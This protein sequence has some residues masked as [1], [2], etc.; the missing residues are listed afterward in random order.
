MIQSPKKRRLSLSVGAKIFLLLLILSVSAMGLIAIIALYT[1]GSVG[2]SAAASSTSLGDRAVEDSKAA[3][4]QSA[5][6]HL[7]KLASDQADISDTLFQ[8]VAAETTMVGGYASYLMDNPDADLD[9]ADSHGML[10][11]TVFLVPNVNKADV[12]LESGLLENMDVIFEQVALADPHITHIYIGTGSGIMRVYPPSDLPSTY[13]HRTRSWFTAAGLKGN[14]TWSEPYI[15]AGGR[16]LM[17]TCSVPVK[18]ETSRWE[19]VVGTDV[20]VETINQK[21]I[22]T[23]I[24]ER[25]YAFLLDNKGNVIARPGLSANDTR[26]DETFASENALESTNPEFRAVAVR[27]VAGDTGVES[28]TI[29]GEEKYVA[30]APIKSTGWS[31]GI[32]V[33]VSSV[34]APARATGAKISAISSETSSDIR[35]SITFMNLAFI[36]IFGILIVVV[37]LCSVWLARYITGPVRA[38]KEGSAAIGNGNLDVVVKVDSGD[39]FEDLA[40]S[41]NTM[42]SDLKDHIEELRRTTAE[43]ERM[44]RE[45]ELAKG[46]QQSFLPSSIPHIEGADLAAINLPALEVGGDFY[47]FIPITKDNWGLAIADVSGKGVPAALFMA[48]SRTLL[49]ASA[50]RNPTPIDAIMR[51]NHLIAED[52]RSGMFVTLFYAIL[53][54]K[55]RRLVYVNAGHNPPLLF[56]KD[57]GTVNLLKA[58]GIPLGVQE[59]MNLEEQHVMLETGDIVVLYTDGV[60]EA[61]NENEDFFG[62]E[63]LAAVV[64]DNATKSA[65]QILDAIRDAVL[66]FAG[67]RPQY[68]DITLMVLKLR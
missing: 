58:E 4:E 50:T 2:N 18:S 53:E 47:D 19:W 21:I 29:G 64:R 9:P 10:R 5:E 40:N 3:L 68:D 39:E 27:M 7:L 54:A 32:V 8:K 60:T 52:A 48:L 44:T 36:A 24:G 1:I 49:R 57:G 15:D 61:M 41:F 45:L 30:F 33:P 42:T 22:S 34:T 51:A 28:V 66:T 26:W 59:D 13:D 17:V 37:A 12:S 25:S 56:P 67:D 43:K 16:G 65:Q 23:Q 63:R 11:S 20:T 35:D 55:N 46:I 31:V 6:I 38:L 62:D 14:M